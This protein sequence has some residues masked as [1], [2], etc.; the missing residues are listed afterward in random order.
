MSQASSRI[1]PVIEKLLSRCPFLRDGV[2]LT[3]GPYYVAGQVA[4]VISS[5]TLSDSEAASVFSHMHEMAEGDI[6]VR[7]LLMVGILEVLTD[8]EDSIERTRVG[9]GYGPA[10]SLFEETLNFWRGET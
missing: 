2:D 9:L 8:S 10:R 3:E 1:D 6:Q 5:G 4:R 7:N